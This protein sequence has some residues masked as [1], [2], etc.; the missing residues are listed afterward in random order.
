MINLD[1]MLMGLLVLLLGW[2]LLCLGLGGN[3]G[4]FDG[5][6][7]IFIYL[8]FGFKI[9]SNI[10]HFLEVRLKIQSSQLCYS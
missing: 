2:E 8:F 4:L 7:F 1:W 5:V 10:I 9:I 6:L 3:L